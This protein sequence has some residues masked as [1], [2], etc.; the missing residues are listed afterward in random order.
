M[1]TAMVKGLH[2]AWEQTGDEAAPPV[3]L[4]MGLGAPLTY[5]EDAFCER[6]AEPGYRVI[7]MDNRDVGQSSLIDAPVPD[8]RALILSSERGGPAIAPYTLSDMG[9]DVVG[10]L[11]ALGIP[12]AH[13]VGVSLGG[14][15]AQ[16]VA[17]EHPGRVGTLTSMMSTTGDRSL[18]RGAPEAIKALLTP[19]PKD[20]EA[21]IERRMRSWDATR[22][23]AYPFEVARVRALLER[24]F[25]RGQ[26]AAGAARQL[27]AAIAAPSRRQALLQL[28]VPTLVMHGQ[29]DPLIPVQ[30][31]RD[32]HAHVPGSRYV[33]LEGWGHDL[34]SG[35]WEVILTELH[36][37]LQAH[38]I[39]ESR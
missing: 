19:I 26:P 28:K 2:I 10:L 18:P 36:Q 5:W 16:T 35:F 24:S 30:A 11:D 12:K 8:L 3:L 21:A 27:A 34:H 32:T 20:R 15:V 31:G 6:L 23:P 38:P 22:S 33:E 39:E 7:R 9:A 4:I 13:L 37:H 1:P 29:A 25:D 14:M 17:I